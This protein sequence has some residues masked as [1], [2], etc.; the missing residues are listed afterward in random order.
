MI[1]F[2]VVACKDIFRFWFELISYYHLKL[3]FILVPAF[4]LLMKEKDLLALIVVPFLME[5]WLFGH[6]ELYTEFPVFS[7]IIF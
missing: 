5:L 4:I 2:S 3:L 6:Q 1:C 7:Q